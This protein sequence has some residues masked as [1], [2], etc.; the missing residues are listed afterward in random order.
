MRPAHRGER[1]VQARQ[2]GI[3]LRAV[4]AL[5]LT[6]Q[7]TG[8]RPG[9]AAALRAQLGDEGVGEIEVELAEHRDVAHRHAGARRRAGVGRMGLGGQGPKV[10]VGCQHVG[11]R[12][13]VQPAERGECGRRLSGTGL[14]RGAAPVDVG[15][16]GLVEREPLARL[17]RCGLDAGIDA[18]VVGDEGRAF[19]RGSGIGHP[20]GA[21][22]RVAI[23]ISGRGQP[24]GACRGAQVGWWGLPGGCH[25]GR[26]V[27]V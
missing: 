23:V 16:G 11:S 26:E 12:Q 1:L 27:R 7:A 24:G 3:A 17:G 14:L 6:R 2:L 19:G 20:H 18:P 13:V 15:K 10:G 5:L 25:R 9:R 8:G 22:R 4:Q 21:G